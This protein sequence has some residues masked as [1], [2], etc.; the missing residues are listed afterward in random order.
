MNFQDKLKQIGQGIKTFIDK[1]MI[2]RFFRVSYD[3]IWNIILFFLVIGLLFFFFIGGIGAGYFASLI[4]DEP[5]R[6]SEEMVSAIYNY[7]ETS[8]IYFANNV[9]LGEV[10]S[11]LHRDVT[12]LDKVSQ[13]IING[14]IATEDEYF[15]THEGIVPKAI[16]RAVFQEVTGSNVQTGGST[17][18][19]Q[20]IKNQ[21]LTNEV[22]FD[23]KAK[24]I[25]LAMRLENFMEK[26]EILEAYLNISP[27]GRNSN[28]RNIAGIQTAAQGIFGVDADEV[29]L[30][31]AAFLAGLPQSPIG[32]S[33]FTNVGT[34]KSEEGLEAGLSRMETVLSRMLSAGYITE[35]QYQEA[36]EFDLIGSLAERLPTTYDEYPYL[37][38]EVR[39][40][41]ESI[42]KEK[43]ALEDGYTLEELESSAE[44]NEQYQIYAAR[45]LSQGGYKIHT[46]INKEIYDKFQEVTAN[47]NNF[48]RDKTAIV[49]EGNETRTIM[50]E[51][52][53]TEELIPLVQQQQAGAVLRDNATG[54]I[55]AFVAGRDFE[56]DNVNFAVG[57]TRRQVGS[58]AKPI[59]VY[60]PAYEE[61][62]LQ[63][64][65]ILPD[66]KFVDNSGPNAWSPSNFSRGRYY[67]LVT[68]RRAMVSSYNVSTAYGYIQLLKQA[69]PIPDYLV[70]MGF[71]HIPE[72]QYR[73]PAMALGSFEATVEE[74]TSAFST[75]GNNGQ[76][77][78]SYMIE[79]IETIDGEV[80]YQHESEPVDVF[81]PQTS[82]L[83]ID[84]MRDVLTSGT[85]GTAR[86]NLRNP[87]VDWAGKTGTSN[88]LVDAWFV[89][90]NPNV[91][92]GTWMGYGYRQSL[93]D[94]YSGRNQTYW[95]QLV[96]AATEIDPEL[97]APAGRFQ[98]PGGLVSRS[99]SLV[100]GQPPSEITRSLGLVGSD[101]FNANFAPTGTD[102]SLI[103]GNYVI[104]DGKAVIPGDQTPSEFIQGDGLI[105]NP[106]WLSDVGYDKLDDISQ[107]I[108]LNNSAWEGIEFPE[109][110]ASDIQDTGKAPSTPRSLAKSGNTLKWNASSSN[111]VV[112]YRVYRAANPDDNQFNLVDAVIETELNVG[113]RDAVYLVVAV[114]YF[115]RESEP[116]EIYIDGDFEK[117]DE[118]NDNETDSPGDNKGNNENNGNNGNNENPPSSDE[119]DEND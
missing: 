12:T 99:F 11:D 118:N 84:V 117:E 80:V 67:G 13:D 47:F 102:N 49:R 103:K 106:E 110:E 50:T 73:L 100:S 78:D 61:G 74:N 54:A 43:L 15:E 21:I 97:M 63:P 14:L 16:L 19:Q 59:L 114:D 65:S 79:K 70:K 7:E 51:D 1:G 18:T 101:L 4:K 6:S 69:N 88:D 95:A 52:P 116:S 66:A 107:L 82:Y 28:G 35:A 8:E 108:P 31:Q 71:D 3:V 56:R 85:G 17:L 96:N 91:T 68:A 22:S 92:L 72:N 119:S 46:T 98:Q 23:R 75:Y 9:F 94:G 115:G 10:S 105:F 38:E 32:Y 104:V 58:T 87:G 27:F 5:L 2:Q 81:S 34:V 57:T 90:T 20:I 86:A 55:I 45:E 39:R 111:N 40:R 41:V 25:V 62:V 83:I 33:P 44:L 93:D 109:L 64:G 26:D 113:N 77:V 37:S 89:A 42:F 76:F 29:N 30:A 112:G 36:L 60:G 53:E 24:E 48:G